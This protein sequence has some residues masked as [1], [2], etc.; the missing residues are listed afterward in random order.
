[1]GK[2]GQTDPNCKAHDATGSVYDDPVKIV[3][4][5]SDLTQRK[6]LMSTGLFLPGDAL[7]SPQNNVTVSE[8]DKITLLKPL[9]YGAGD[10]RIRGNGDAD[11]LLYKAV[12]A[13]FCMD[14]D[15]ERYTEGKDFK[16]DGKS[17]IWKW[18]GK[19]GREP[20]IGRRYTIKY[21]AFI[22]WIAFFPP[23]ERFSHGE[24]LG[25][26]VMLRKLHIIAAQQSGQ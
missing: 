1:M 18:Q 5:F 3:G 22:D 11:P 19:D 14:E 25:S 7:F 4:L 17:I 15:R 9:P 21:R 6:E 20:S 10:A 26:K 23:M 13:I 8:G 16:L 2:D 12:S 24:D